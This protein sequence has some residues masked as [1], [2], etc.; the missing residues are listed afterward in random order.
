MCFISVEEILADS[1]S[2]P[3]DMETDQRK[4]VKRKQP[5]TW[6][7]EDPETIVDFTDPNVVSKITG[8]YLNFPL[9]QS[10]KEYFFSY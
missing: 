1:D 7:E 10:I 5:N 3:E 6:I 8:V 4:I 9:F 2:D